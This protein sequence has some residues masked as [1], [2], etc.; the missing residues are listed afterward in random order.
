MKEDPVRR[1]EAIMAKL[2]SENGCP[3]DR[4]QTHRSLR[5]YLIEEAYEAVEAIDSGDPAKIR[6]ELGDVLLQVVFHAQVARENGGFTLDDIAEGICEKMVR[7]HPHVF[8]NV[9]VDGVDGVLANWQR[10][11]QEEKGGTSSGK[12][13]VLAGISRGLP[14][15]QRAEQIQARAAKVGFDWSSLNGPLEKVDEEIHELLEAWRGRD[16]E[17]PDPERVEEEFGDVLFSLV[18]VARFLGVH[19]ELALNRAVDKFIRRFQG[20]ERL[21]EGKPLSSMDLAEMDRLW[22]QMKEREAQGQ[23]SE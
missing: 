6:E 9:H 5:P 1:L 21:A 12:T 7:R 17:L 23:R 16:R 22:E 20:M 2:R 4:E 15:L 19:P 13:S 10:I 18:N 14:A 8:G 11:K 3:W